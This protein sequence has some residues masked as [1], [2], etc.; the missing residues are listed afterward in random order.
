MVV[1]RV[2]NFIKNINKDGVEAVANN[3]LNAVRELKS[4][5]NFQN[6]KLCNN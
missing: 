3:L 6:R 1:K 2:C 4:L 5:M